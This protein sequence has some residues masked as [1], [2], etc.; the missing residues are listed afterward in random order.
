MTYDQ[1]SYDLGVKF[2]LDELGGAHPQK[3]FDAKAHALACVIQAAIEDFLEELRT[4]GAQAEQ[5]A[6]TAIGTTRIDD[7]VIDAGE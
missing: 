7:D 4:V 3:D 6:Q 5:P 2:L 1:G